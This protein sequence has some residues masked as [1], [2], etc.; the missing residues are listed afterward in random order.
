M[1][2][3]SGVSSFIKK[4]LSLKQPNDN[5][6]ERSA[7]RPGDRMEDGFLLV[8]QSTSERSTVYTNSFQANQIDCPPGYSEVAQSNGLPSYSDYQSRSQLY[9]PTVDNSDFKYGNPFQTG[10]PTTQSRASSS[11][12]QHE[13]AALAGMAYSSPG[14]AN[15]GDTSAKSP[16][17]DVPF[18]LGANLGLLSAADELRASDLLNQRTFDHSCYEYDFSVEIKFLT[19]HGSFNA[20]M[21]WQGY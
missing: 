7:P 16:I 10:M 20:D 4:N 2:M 21:D 9:S 3:L 8:G 11:G 5:S 18:T 12:V 1:E 13:N 6:V 15:F 14:E 19:E 17:A